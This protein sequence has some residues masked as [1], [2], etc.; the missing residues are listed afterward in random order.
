MVGKERRVRELVHHIVG[1]VV[2]HPDLFE[3]DVP[4][5]LHLIGSE[6]GPPH[7]VGENVER[8]LE[9]IVGHPHVER[10][11]LLGREGVHVAADGL[12]RGRDI[13]RG[14]V[15]RSLEEQVLQEVAGAE[16]ALVFVDRAGSNP[17]ANG[18]G[19]QVGH[20]LGHD[21]SAAD[22]AHLDRIVAL[23]RSAVGAAIDLSDTDGFD[24]D[25]RIRRSR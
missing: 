17:E 9:V 21:P 23:A 16:L 14:P 11:V 24:R 10:G 25:P 15:G 19:S 6:R 2:A 5:G 22:G 3:N 4:L 13:R 18:Y 8:Q 7:D 20:S 12:D 1:R